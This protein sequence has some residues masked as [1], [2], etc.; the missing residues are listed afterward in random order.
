MTNESICIDI[1]CQINDEV[2]RNNRIIVT[3]WVTK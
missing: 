1:N 3:N 2:I